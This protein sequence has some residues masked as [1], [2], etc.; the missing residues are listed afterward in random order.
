MLP[1]ASA[2][3]MPAAASPVGRQVSKRA[4]KSAG[5][6]AVEERLDKLL[7]QMEELQRQNAMMMQELAELRRENTTL[8]R[9]LQ[10]LN[11]TGG[12]ATVAV[13]EGS[14]EPAHPLSAGGR[15]ASMRPR[16]DSDPVVLAGRPATPPGGV[17]QDMVTDSPAKLAEP[18][19][20]RSVVSPEPPPQHDE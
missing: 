14:G 3:A 16:E 7:A 1:K 15:R 18:D 9:R 5:T 8:R 12:S 11:S 13:A 17:T 10:V 20:K 6:S 2:V 4:G 19:L